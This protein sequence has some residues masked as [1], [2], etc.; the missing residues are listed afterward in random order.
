VAHAISNVHGRDIQDDI[1][2]VMPLT[3]IEYILAVMFFFLK[4]CIFMPG[5]SNS[6]CSEGQLWTY[7]VTRGLHHDYQGLHYD[8]DATMAVPKPY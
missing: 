4:V 5:I 1:R 8:T 7:E 6:N 3:F 2:G